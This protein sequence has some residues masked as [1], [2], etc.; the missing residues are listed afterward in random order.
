MFVRKILLLSLFFVSQLNCMDTS[1]NLSHNSSDLM[2]VQNVVK[3]LTQSQKFT[4]MKRFLALWFITF[5][6]LRQILFIDAKDQCD[7]HELIF[8]NEN[9]CL[10]HEAALLND[11]MEFKK[12]CERSNGDIKSVK[13]IEESLD[14]YW[15]SDRGVVIQCSSIDH[16][17]EHELA[18]L[19]DDCKESNEYVEPIKYMEKYC[20][21]LY[22]YRQ[23][24]SSYL[25]VCYKDFSRYIIRELKA[26]PIVGIPACWIIDMSTQGCMVDYVKH[27]E[28]CRSGYRF[29]RWYEIESDIEKV[30]PKYNYK[31]VFLLTISSIFAAKYIYNKL[32]MLH[33]AS[34]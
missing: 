30:N 24:E 33:A 1:S 29:K 18:L 25:W 3:N 8:A 16:L 22:S 19:N 32:V 12:N 7:T 31:T 9:Q 14:K 2:I 4:L 13:G 17:I 34:K 20:K 21:N 6:L 15:T 26:N 11:L 23:A 28:D 5:V 27:H 10:G